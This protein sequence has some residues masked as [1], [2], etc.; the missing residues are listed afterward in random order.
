VVLEAIG[1]VQETPLDEWIA[2]GRSSYFAPFRI[3]PPYDGAIP[4][5][6]ESARSYLGRPYDVLYELDDEKIYCSE[7]IKAFGAA[8]ASLLR[9]NRLAN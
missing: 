2:R 9:P 1:P 3:V 4:R 6:L 8:T 5:F 7:L